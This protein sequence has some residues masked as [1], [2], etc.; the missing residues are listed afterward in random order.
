MVIV[1]AATNRSL[2]A[3]NIVIQTLFGPEFLVSV[4]NY[5]NVF[6]REIWKNVWMISNGHHH[7]PA[8]AH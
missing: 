8:A 4:Q 5:R 1:H 6:K 3:E 7:T 2:A